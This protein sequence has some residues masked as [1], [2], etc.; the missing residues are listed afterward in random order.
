MRPIVLVSFILGL[1]VTPQPPLAIYGSLSSSAVLPGATFSAS[2]AIYSTSAE[3]LTL[4]LDAPTP[5]GMTLLATRWTTDTI[6]YDHPAAITLTYRV[7]Q[8]PPDG[9]IQTM[10]YTVKDGAGN[11]AARWL[12]LRVG[13]VDWP[14]PKEYHR[15]YLPVVAR[16]G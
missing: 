8:I 14:A 1:L 3:P 9:Q 5:T 12:V 7:D 11:L 6:S 15:L 10:A 13:A 2:L 4:E 16:G